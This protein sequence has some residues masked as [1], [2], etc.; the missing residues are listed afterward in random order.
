MSL[1]RFYFV[2]NMRPGLMDFQG[3]QIIAVYFVN[4]PSDSSEFPISSVLR[5]IYKV[6][7]DIVKSI[8]ITESLLELSNPS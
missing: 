6:H 2:H 1:T 3:R 4:A 5:V 7:K 8:F